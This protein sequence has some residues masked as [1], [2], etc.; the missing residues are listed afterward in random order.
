MSLHQLVFPLS[1]ALMVAA[2]SGDKGGDAPPAEGHCERL[3]L[4]VRR[5]DVFLGRQRIARLRKP[6]R[7]PQSR[8]EAGHRD[9]PVCPSIFIARSAMSP[10]RAGS[11]ARNKPSPSA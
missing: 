1:L 2:C 9:S 11:S 6:E 8:F 4:R 3:E 10:N 5:L 7:R